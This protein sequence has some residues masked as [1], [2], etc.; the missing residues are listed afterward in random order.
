M[1][2]HLALI[3]QELDH[4]GSGRLCSSWCKRYQVRNCWDSFSWCLLI[5]SR[6][7]SISLFV[8]M[9]GLRLLR[10]TSIFISVPFALF[11]LDIVGEV[12]ATRKWLGWLG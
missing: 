6:L 8:C 9:C 3:I 1:H 12:S 5:T 11:F 7:I 2:S 4:L 10:H